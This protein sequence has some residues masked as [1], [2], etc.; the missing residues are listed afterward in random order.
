MKKFL[1]GLL[2]MIMTLS[3]I[4]LGLA[5]N[6]ESMIV[7]T[8]DEVVKESV[9]NEVVKYAEK[10]TGIEKEKIKKQVTEVLEKN[11]AIKKTLDESLDKA[12]DIL[13]GKEIDN[14]T[15]ANE[16][17]EI[18][19]NSEEILKEYG[20]ALTK[21][22]KEELLDMVNNEEFTK[23]FNDTVLE[24]KE[25]I[26]TEAKTAV[27][28]FNFV[29]ST[30]FEFILIGIILFS[31]VC[32]ALLKKSYFKW[33][34]NFGESTIVTGVICGILMPI[35]TNF[36]NEELAK[37]MTETKVVLVLD[38]LKQYGYILLI[39]GLMAIIINII[40]T[41]VTKKETIKEA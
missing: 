11:E 3:F 31:L 21:E 38:S 37:N 33:L 9:A 8:I 28:T 26:P 41:K 39:L 29:R 35:L 40:L 27:D 20:V 25:N 16:V 36:I 34:A 2:T 1:I 13:S 14:F 10:E 23:T 4:T 30:T 19:T 6:L 32:I 17:E 22:E 15:I 5:M 24:I 12:L 7:G 18:I